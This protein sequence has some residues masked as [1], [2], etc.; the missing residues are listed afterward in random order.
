MII[1]ENDIILIKTPPGIY[2]LC[3]NE[4]AFNE[5]KKVYAVDEN[6]H[7]TGEVIFTKDYLTLEWELS[8][9]NWYAGQHI[10]ASYPLWKQSNITQAEDVA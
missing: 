3:P 2:D 6:G 8:D 7:P 10:E 9:I 5:M 4:A 1:K